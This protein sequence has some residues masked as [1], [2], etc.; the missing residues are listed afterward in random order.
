MPKITGAQFLA[1]SLNAY[2]VTH[3]FFVPAI[4]N[5]TLAEIEKRTQIKRILT[6]SEIAVYMADG[7]ARASGRVRS[8]LR[9]AWG[10][11]I[12]RLGCVIHF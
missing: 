9:N 5:H 12:W 4:L 11:P 2:G 7:Y 10:R 8:H 6:H 1:D 3:V